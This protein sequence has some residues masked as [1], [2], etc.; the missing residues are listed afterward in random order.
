MASSAVTP[1]SAAPYPVLVGTATTGAGVRPPTTLARAPSMPAM[2]TTASAMARVSSSAR[3]RCSPATPQSVSWV[4]AKPSA[5]STAVHSV[6]TG[7]SAVPAVMTTTMPVLEGA[8]RKTTVERDPLSAT[9]PGPK[10]SATAAA[11]TAF[12]CASVARVEQD[13]AVGLRE[14]LF[15]D[16]RTVLRRLARAVDGFGDAEAQVAVMVHPGEPQVRIG[17][18]AQL[19]DGVVRRAASGRDVFDERAKR[20][21]VHDLLYPAQL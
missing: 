10:P 2:T 7:R 5:P 12:T 21:S 3:S 8:G 13:R 18:A 9:A 6:A 19:P 14:E 16:G 1:S 20:G 15:D 4:G 11:V 17:E